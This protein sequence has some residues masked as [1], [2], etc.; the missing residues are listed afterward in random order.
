[1]FCSYFQEVLKRLSDQ[2]KHSWANLS[3]QA[4][5]TVAKNTPGKTQRSK[6]DI[7]QSHSYVQFWNQTSPT[8]MENSSVEGSDLGLVDV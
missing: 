7:G 3:F 1:M 4:W 8:F 6:L 5:R 2:S